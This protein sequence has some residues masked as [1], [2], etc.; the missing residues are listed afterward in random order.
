[1][2]WHIKPT[3]EKTPENIIIHCD[4]KFVSANFIVSILFCWEKNT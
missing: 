3:T 1:M 4:T 2:R